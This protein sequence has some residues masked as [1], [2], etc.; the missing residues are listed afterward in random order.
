[1]KK[2][3]T[4]MRLR[5]LP[6]AFASIA[7]GAFLAASHNSFVLSIFIF[8]V[9]TTLL[10]QILSNLANDYGDSVHGA[11]NEERKG[12]SRAVQ[13]GALSPS[14]M[15]KAIIITSILSLVS[16]LY[17]LHIS[18]LNF[19]EYL[20]FIGFGLLA[21]IAAILY[22]NGK[23]PYG[24]KGLG[25]I[26]VFIFF[27]LLAVVGS[28]YLQTRNLDPLI[29][30]PGTSVGLFTVAVLNINNIRD[31]ESDLAAG[32]KSIPARLG[33]KN[34]VVYHAILLTGG[35]MASLV[36]V[37]LNFTSIWQLS[38]LVILPAL[39]IN[40]NAVRTKVEAG[41]LDPYLKQMALTTL[42][43]VI[44]FGVTNMN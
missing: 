4:A 7:M 5:T 11:D 18:N 10:L 41:L 6:L 20:I 37:S 15:K 33:R 42:I 8:C 27:G 23:L 2:W 9:V 30:L 12:P 14:A 24:Y 38:F 13:S 39:L 32:K 40:F 21:I 1:M 16:G 22:T 19:S 34:A 25:D 31:I 35:L 3:I 44:V 26:S 43:F 28:Y 17:L 36:Y 29:F